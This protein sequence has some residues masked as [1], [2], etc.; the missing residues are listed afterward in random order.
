MRISESKFGS[1]VMKFV[2]KVAIASSLIL[3]VT[4]AVLGTLQYLSV[5]ARLQV[6][7]EESIQDIVHGVK[8]TV[9][10]ELNGKKG[11]A[12]YATSLAQR[13]PTHQNITNVI[14][15]PDIKKEFLLIGGGYESDGSNFKSD[16]DWDP[17]ATWDPRVRPWY[18]KAK[19]ERALIITEPY[20]DSAT[21][22]ILISVATPLLQSG[23]FLGAIFFDL[24]LSGL[25][26]LVNRVKLFDAGYIFIVSETGVVIAHPETNY[27]GKNM[28]EFL[29]NTRIQTNTIDHPI[30]DGNE[31]NLR[32]AKIPDQD[33]YIGVLLDEKIAYKAVAD[34]RNQVIIFSI[35]ALLA[36]VTL[37]LLLLNRL[38]TP[39]NALNNA[40]QNIASGEG[41]LTKRLSTNSDQEFAQL[42][43]GFNQFTVNLQENVKLLKSTGDDVLEGMQVS[44]QGVHDSNHAI[45]SQLR[46]IDLL[47]TAM[48]QMAVTASEVA[49]N[50]QSAAAA[51]QEADSA[52]QTGVGIVE[53]TTELI[54]S[55]STRIEDAVSNVEILEKATNNIETVLQVIN[56]IAEQT[57]L[58][59][60]NAA[61]EAARAG[62]QGRGFAVVADEVR[63]LASRT[64]DSTTEI[65]AMIDQL[66]LG[67][68]TVVDA[69]K[70]SQG[71]AQET[72]EQA[73]STQ[74]ALDKIC[75]AINLIN[76]MNIQIASAAEEQSSV[77][78]E[79]NQN[80]VRIRDISNEVSD[81]AK[82]TSASIDSQASSI[83][84]QKQILDNFKV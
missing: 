33:W 80:T 26:D 51:A 35:V 56:E 19:Q 65:R 63:T 82:Q 9:A 34:M 75:N 52:T 20:A 74:Q 31:Y 49:N 39:L 77:S 79:I 7:M 15:V 3:L 8:N 44:Q 5:K 27:N 55:L 12:S 10:S 67:V 69:M 47:A 81:Y 60:L 13:D 84:E 1:L 62:E 64:Q 41:D 53:Q 57:N 36:S 16:P 22:E 24:S 30:I 17:G 61:I 21:G 70:S 40:I 78:D 66:Q 54:G 50:A 68:K 2:Y 11:I 32:F 4:I 73:Q 23:Q 37:L 72:V 42:A 45:S 18:I 6:K 83:E 58:L 48:N 59:A 76:D 29:P 38:L 25:S 28:R 46:E 14:R 71:A 43:H